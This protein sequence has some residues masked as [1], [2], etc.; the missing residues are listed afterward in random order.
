[1][2]RQLGGVEF[3]GGQDATTVLVDA[4][5]PG[6]ECRGQGSVD[7]VDHL[8]GSSVWSGAAPFAIAGLHAHRAGGEIDGLQVPLEGRKSLTRIGFTGK[9][10][11]ASFLQGFGFLI[12]LPWAWRSS[13]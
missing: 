8:V 12:T 11:A 9:G 10:G 3:I 4:G 5:L 7:L 2:R 13:A 6:R 1:V